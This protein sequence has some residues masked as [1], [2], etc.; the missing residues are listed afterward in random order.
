MNEN[1]RAL[2]YFVKGAIILT[3]LLQSAAYVQ[4]AELCTLR[5]QKRT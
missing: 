4:D 5:E 1:A 2:A 3:A